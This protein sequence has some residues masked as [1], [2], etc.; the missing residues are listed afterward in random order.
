MTVVAEDEAGMCVAT[1]SQAIGVDTTPPATGYITINGIAD[2]TV[3]FAR[4]SSELH[5]GWEGFV[6]E[7][8]GLR[9][10]TVK[11]FECKKCINGTVS[12]ELC[13]IIDK[14]TV[15][16]DNMSSFYELTLSSMRAYYVVLIVHNGADLETI[17]QSSSIL[18]D[19]SSPLPGK[20]KITSNWDT[21]TTFQSSTDTLVGLLSIASSDFDYVCPS[22]HR[23]FPNMGTN[24]MHNVLDSFSSDFLVVNST[25][26]YLG[27][28]YNSDLTLI[29][30]SG[31][32]SDI[33]TLHSG[34]YTFTTTAAIGLMTIT[35]VGIVTDQIAIPYSIEEKPEENMFDIN[36]FNNVTGLQTSNISL[37]DNETVPTP[38]TDSNIQF[39]ENNDTNERSVNFKSDEY[40]FGIHFLGYKISSNRDWHHIFWATNKYTTILRWFTMATPPNEI[41]SYTITVKQR[42]EFLKQTLDL[43]LVVNADELV[44]ISGFQF[45]GEIHLV[46]LTWNENDYMPPLIDI[47]NPF[48]SDAFLKSIDIPDDIDKPCRH[49]IGFYDGESAIKELWLGV[50]DNIKEPG[51]IKPMELSQRFCFPCIRPC[52]GLCELPCNETF[53]TE[54]FNLISIQ[55][56]GLSMQSQNQEKH[57]AN[58]TSEEPCNSTAYYINAKL[59]NFAG[60]E[61]YAF[62]NGI[63]IDTTSPVCYYVK[64]TDPNF[65][66]DQP[67]H[68]LGSSSS[69]GAYW[70]CTESE[71]QI[72]DHKVEV[73]HIQ[74]GIVVLNKT[75]VGLGTKYHVLLDNGTLDDMNDYQLNVYVSNTAGL[76]TTG[77]C[78]VRVNLYPPDVSNVDSDVLFT[79]GS[80]PS[81][82]NAPYWASSQTAIGM[83]WNGGTTNTEF[84]GNCMGL[85]FMLFYLFSICFV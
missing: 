4:K 76:I 16:S 9:Y 36:T 39:Q 18:V 11:L 31:I 70:N 6:D 82:P 42:T 72:V 53:L 73:V 40:G 71:S 61:T 51:N 75:S 52:F 58:I 26:A 81:S 41:T 69:I 45:Y 68:Y 84:Y 79:D 24:S 2:S 55:Q 3:I 35:T 15:Y 8:S 23:H 80:T 29:T 37:D 34:N 10:T 62:S 30:K 33:L 43:T 64:C 27:I 85:F 14:R 57:C 54:G 74:S 44:S 46:T 7:E 25:G 65:S 56:S 59:I 5:V 78:S 83:Q 28:G 1:V 19:E 60:Q 67:T 38:K 49:G 32:M 77:S 12:N 63:Q 48:Y 20:V 66:I 21:E 17:V 22:Q 47:Y 50:S 13:L